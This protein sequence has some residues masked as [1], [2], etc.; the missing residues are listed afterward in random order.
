MKAHRAEG[1]KPTFHV[2]VEVGY[3]AK[4]ALPASC[5]A[6]GCVWLTGDDAPKRHEVLVGQPL[7]VQLGSHRRY[8]ARCSGGPNVLVSEDIVSVPVWLDVSPSEEIS[9]TRF[10]WETPKAAVGSYQISCLE[11][12]GYALSFNVDVVDR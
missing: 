1:L 10:I 11:S 9:S 4:A 2:T 3:D 12:S 6:K 7:I 5:K 8:P